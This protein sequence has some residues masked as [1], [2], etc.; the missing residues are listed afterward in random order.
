MGGVQ[1]YRGY[2]NAQIVCGFKYD[3]SLKFTTGTSNGVKTCTYNHC[4]VWK[5]N[6]PCKAADKFQKL[7]G[8]CATPADGCTNNN[9]GF[10]TGC[11]SY[12]YKMTNAWSEDTKY[13]LNYNKSYKK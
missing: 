9:C 3:G 8:C 12:T 7:N 10:K 11:D 6:L 2:V 5:Q 4:F 13:C 1:H